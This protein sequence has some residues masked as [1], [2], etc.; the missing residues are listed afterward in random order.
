MVK[1][2]DILDNVLNE[3]KALPEPNEEPTI[4]KLYTLAANG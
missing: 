1:A 3:K 2:V 4:Q